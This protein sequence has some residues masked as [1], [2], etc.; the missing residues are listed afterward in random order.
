MSATPHLDTMARRSHAFCC[1]LLAERYA[2][3]VALV[4]QTR[5][6]RLTLMLA[7]HRADQIMHLEI[8]KIGAR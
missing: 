4:T 3:D 6:S 1:A 2:G 7:V 5:A 8:A